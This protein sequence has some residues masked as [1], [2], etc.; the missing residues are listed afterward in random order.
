MDQKLKAFWAKINSSVAD[1]WAKD[2]LFLILFGVLIVIVKFRDV[3]LSILINS[4]KRLFDNA[5]KKDAALS[6]EETA[7]K[8][9]ANQ[10]VQ[11]AKDAPSKQKPVDAD[12]YKNE[13]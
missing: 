13:K 8:T 2:K 1:L 7:D 3:F 4:A 11:D 10:L 5:Q 12:W 6:Q 9:K